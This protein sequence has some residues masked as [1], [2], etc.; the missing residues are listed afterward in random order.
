[1]TWRPMSNPTATSSAS[2]PAARQ[3][4]TQGWPLFV[5][6]LAIVVAAVVVTPAG[7]GAPTPFTEPA[8][9]LLALSALTCGALTLTRAPDVIGANAVIGVAA[10]VAAI[11]VLAPSTRNPLELTLTEYL[12][13]GPWRYAL[14]PIAVHLAFAIGWPHRHRYWFG[15]AVGWYLLHGAMFLAVV[16]GI[17]AV[18][19]PLVRA[20]DETVRRMILEP[21]GAMVAL[22][23]LGIASVSPARRA[24]ERRAAAWTFTA[25]L[26]GLVPLL[27]VDLFAGVGGL[28][29]EG[30]R[31]VPLA[32]MALPVLSLIGLLTLPFIDAG[33]RDSRALVIAQ[34]VLEE[35]ELAAAL[36][37]L[38]NDLRE[39]FDAEGV[40]VRLA[41]PPAQAQVGRVRAAAEAGSLTVDAETSDDR[42]VLVAPIGRSG[43]PLGEVRLEAR[44]SGAYGRREREWLV[45][46]LVPVG[47]ALRARRRETALTERSRE[48]GDAIAG[49]ASE[50]L[51]VV[52]RLPESPA[53][54]GMAVPPPVDAREV[55]AQLA[56]GISK[57]SRQG[58]GVEEQS[59]ATRA[60]VRSASDRIANALD[61]LS[62]LSTNLRALGAHGEEIELSNQTVSG[63][64][65][66]TNLLANNAALEATR[67][68]SAGRTFGVLAE[69][70]RRLADTTAAT[71]EA[72]G[73]KTTA[74]ATDVGEVV[75]TLE[76]IVTALAEAIRE[77]ES[78]EDAARMLGTAAADLE[79]ASR[80]LRPALEEARAVAERRS[81][82][83]EHLTATLERFLDDR[84][85][86][87]RALATHREAL[88]RV[89]TS[90]DRVAQ[91][92]G[93]RRQVGTLGANRN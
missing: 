35:A 43:D 91:R 6:A 80:S 66:R 71:S 47:T 36:Q 72:I 50:L 46:F 42:R 24:S 74:L 88:D 26:L 85:S 20:L 57:V 73:G 45:A 37:L 44:H 83:D 19:A 34:R 55:L 3:V 7:G 25:I 22:T 78:G 10:A 15:L 93:Q 17:A 90:L 64:A 38:A 12:V 52:R 11:V 5:S 31:S 54:D 82:R 27:V 48:I 16:G 92:A 21:V 53:D 56:D 32:L 30:I 13:T 77:A 79:S 68:G 41:Q 23:A 29:S 61:A 89:G 65:F 9:L 18:E 62:T 81:A 58:E 67:A 2:V 86:I 59:H 75:A 33:A 4:M 63:V 51:A 8:L 28:A 84:T 39:A 76:S 14:T 70:I 60:K 69:E 87:A 40:S 1:M 49:T